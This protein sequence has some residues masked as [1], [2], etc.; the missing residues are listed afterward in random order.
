MAKLQSNK[1]QAPKS[2]KFVQVHYSELAGQTLAYA[3][4]EIL[5][6]VDDNYVINDDGTIT[7]AM[8]F[9]PLGNW[10]QL[11][12]LMSAY[13]PA[14]NI[15]RLGGRRTFYAMLANDRVSQVVGADGP[16]HAT[17]LLRAIVVSGLLAE[18]RGQIA[19]PEQY[20]ASQVAALAIEKGDTQGALDLAFNLEQSPASSTPPAPA[21]VAPA[22]QASPAQQAIKDASATLKGGDAKTSGQ[23]AQKQPQEAKAGSAQATPAAKAEDKPNA[24]P[25]A[26]EKPAS[27]KPLPQG[28]QAQQLAAHADPVKGGK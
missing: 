21:Q 4:A 7:N 26:Q 13:A 17:A 5:G 19:V 9:D 22:A 27:G 12:P 18:D 3:V 20:L 8:E 1:P 10:N 15:H 25:A 14:F 2:P 16:D 6:T 24:K 23:E 28:K 11:K